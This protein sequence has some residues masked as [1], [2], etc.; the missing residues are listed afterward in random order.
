MFVFELAFEN[1][2]TVSY[3][4]DGVHCLDTVELT[5]DCIQ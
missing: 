1:F 3:Q 2:D 4:F 5:S